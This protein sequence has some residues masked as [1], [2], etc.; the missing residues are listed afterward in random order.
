M[1]NKNIPPFFEELFPRL[2]KID[3]QWTNGSVKRG[4]NLSL[5]TKKF[6]CIRWKIQ[7]RLWFCHQTWPNS[8]IWPTYG[9]S[10]FTS[11]RGTRFLKKG[12]KCFVSHQFLCVLDAK[13]NVDYDF[14]I[15]HDL[16]LWSD[17]L[18]GVQRWKNL[19]F[20]NF[21]QFLQKRP[22]K[23]PYISARRRNFQNPPR[24]IVVLRL[25]WGMIG[26]RHV[27]EPKPR[28]P[29]FFVKKVRFCP[30]LDVFLEK[31]LDVAI[32]DL[33][34]NFTQSFPRPDAELQ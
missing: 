22:R 5:P 20:G 24:I 2:G 3:Q 6:M 14:A 1:G 32:F 23:R 34:C 8:M 11:K 16:I 29:I 13:F 9:H 4:R 17:H 33:R 25:V 15:K 19:F 21:G 26:F 31:K 10:Q 30:S 12:G 28:C 27:S 18:R 7:R